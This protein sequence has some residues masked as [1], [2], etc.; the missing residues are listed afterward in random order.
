MLD[1]T[2]TRKGC[3]TGV[4]LPDVVEASARAIATED[5]DLG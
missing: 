2:D 4:E 3:R 5:K 1:T